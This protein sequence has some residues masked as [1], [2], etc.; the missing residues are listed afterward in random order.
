VPVP[1]RPAAPRPRLA[2]RRGAERHDHRRLALEPRVQ[3][4]GGR[5]H[6]RL[7]ALAGWLW[8]AVGPLVGGSTSSPSSPPPGATTSARWATCTGAWSRSPA[9]SSSWASSSGADGPWPG[10]C[11]GAPSAGCCT[12]PPRPCWRA[13]RCRSR[14]GR[15]AGGSTSATPSPARSQ[16]PARSARTISTSVAGRPP[17]GTSD[18]PTRSLGGCAAVAD[19]F[20]GRLSPPRGLSGPRHA[21]SP[22]DSGA[23]AAAGAG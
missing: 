2:Q 20:R 22:A 4:R 10:R 12:P 15:A 8:R 16:A 1:V 23:R 17:S 9:P 14:R 7:G 18:G 11:W 19:A 3:H 21:A 13:A 5:P 6:H